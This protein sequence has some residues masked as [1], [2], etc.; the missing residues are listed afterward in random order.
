MH[1]LI[2]LLE[3]QDKRKLLQIQQD[4]IDAIDLKYDVEIK[5]GQLHI[6]EKGK[7]IAVLNPVSFSAEQ[8][9]AAIGYRE[10]A[11][12]ALPT[13][14]NYSCILS[15]TDD[16]KLSIDVSQGS[17]E[18]FSL[19]NI[20]TT[21]SDNAFFHFWLNS[22]HISGSIAVPT[23][24]SELEP[25]MLRVLKG[26]SLARKLKNLDQAYS[27]RF[28][29]SRTQGVPNGILKLEI[30]KDA[31]KG[32]VRNVSSH[33]AIEVS[34]PNEGY[35][36]VRCESFRTKLRIGTTKDEMKAIEVIEIAFQKP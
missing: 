35:N 36:I 32:M 17:R 6:L 13:S 16:E 23:V 27:F 24:S 21:L 10:R 4:L 9:A 7:A 5:G 20:P 18:L 28:D 19:T 29:F 22:A 26:F 15:V 31:P 12:K 2:S 11:L 3:D 14:L 1:L 33:L 8:Y 34:L 25:Y 30:T